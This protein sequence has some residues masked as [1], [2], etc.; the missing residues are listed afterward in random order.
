M[1]VEVAI[2]AT[3]VIFIDQ[4]LR[5]FYWDMSRQLGPY[6]ALIITNCIVMGRAEAFAMANPPGKAALDGLANSAGYSLILLYVG[7]FREL[8][9]SGKILGQEVFATVNMGGWYI[10]NGLLVLSPGAFF[11][12]GLFIWAQRS[13]APELQEED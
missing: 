3:F 6:V 4:V 10:P 8:L 5:A 11:L 1:I 9:G 12:I 2:I 7:F 13:M